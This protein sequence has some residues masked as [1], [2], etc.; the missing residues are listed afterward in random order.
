MWGD[1]YGGLG[2]SCSRAPVGNQLVRVH[3]AK[4]GGEIVP[5]G[6]VVAGKEQVAAAIGRAGIAGYGDVAHRSVVEDGGGV[7]A[8]VEVVE[9]LGG[10]AQPFSGLLLY[11]GENAG[12]RGRG[13]RGTAESEEIEVTVRLVGAVGGYGGAAYDSCIVGADQPCRIVST[14]SAHERNVRQIAGA[15]GGHAGAALPGGFGIAAGACSPD[16]PGGG[17]S[18]GV[19]S[20][21]ALSSA[22]AH[23]IGLAGV[24]EVKIVAEG[25]VAEG[26]VVP[27][28]LGNVPERAAIEVRR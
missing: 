7:G 15:V 4:A 10:L 25:S 6:G 20:A 14:R 16:F 5:G 22:A 23:D 1:G 17:V 8:V 3:A 28:G 11:Q 9:F 24:D 21:G 27:G 12:E 13:R 26:R 2:V 19:H 18:G